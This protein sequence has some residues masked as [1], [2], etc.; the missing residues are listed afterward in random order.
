MTTGPPA[1]MMSKYHKQHRQSQ[2]YHAHQNSQHAF[3]ANIQVDQNGFQTV[4]QGEQRK[5]PMIAGEIPWHN[6]AIPAYQKKAATSKKKKA[7]TT[8]AR[9]I[10]R[11]AINSKRPG[12]NLSTQEA[13]STDRN[14]FMT[15]SL[16]KKN[17]L[18]RAKYTQRTHI[19][20]GPKAKSSSN[21]HQGGSAIS[22]IDSY[23]RLYFKV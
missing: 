18:N 22:I 3:I 8:P 20:L 5:T 1:N 10:S 17:S 4:E 23:K 11:T 6:Q 2:E 13:E 21:L 14:N 12:T 15:G 19:D 9:V 7:K 16:N